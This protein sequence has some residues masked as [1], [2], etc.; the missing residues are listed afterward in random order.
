MPRRRQKFWAGCGQFVLVDRRTAY[1]GRLKSGISVACVSV[2]SSPTGERKY[3]L[4]SPSSARNALPSA[5]LFFRL[6]HSFVRFLAIVIKTKHRIS[7]QHGRDT[8]RQPA[9]MA[10][11]DHGRMLQGAQP[12]R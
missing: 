1:V 6:I 3:D 8:R 12:P 11:H 10:R 5:S 2:N 7:R 9:I 4:A